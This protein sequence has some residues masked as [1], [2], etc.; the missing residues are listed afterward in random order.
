MEIRNAKL[1]ISKAGG[2]AGKQ[3]KTYKVTIPT[4]WINNL[5]LSQSSKDLE[6]LYNGEEIII[7][8]KRTPIDFLKSAM[9]KGHNVHIY[10]YMNHSDLCTTI[11][12]D[13]DEKTLKVTNHTESIIRTAFG[14]ND[15]PNWND[16]LDFCEERCVPRTRAN[17]KEILDAWGL[18]EYDPIQIIKI[19]Q[20]KMAEDN[21]WIY[22]EPVYA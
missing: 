8:K 9:T 15:T 5:E 4:N 17:I 20:G 6:L 21:Q 1:S 3:A 7:R 13:F 12:A 2:T 10:K 16:F 22:E 14:N 18:D 11:Y 19:T